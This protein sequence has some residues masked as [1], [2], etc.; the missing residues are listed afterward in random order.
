VQQFAERKPSATLYLRS[1]FDDQIQVLKDGLRYRVW[2]TDPLVSALRF[3][4]FEEIV[5]DAVWPFGPLTGLS[6]PGEK[7]PELGAVRV[8]AEGGDWQASIER[9]MNESEHIIIMVGLTTGLK[10]E[11]QQA[12]IRSQLPRVVLVVPPEN[13][14]AIIRTWRNF[15]SGSTALSSCPEDL[16]THA[17]AVRFGAGGAPVFFTADRRSAAAYRL[18]LYSCWLPM[19]VLAD[20]IRGFSTSPARPARRLS[21]ARAVAWLA[22]SVAGSGLVLARAPGLMDLLDPFR[23]LPAG[24]VSTST[25]RLRVGN[26]RFLDGRNGPARSSPVYKAGTP[27]VVTYQVDGAAKNGEGK[28]DLLAQVSVREPGGDEFQHYTWQFNE[29]MPY[30]QR[31][32]M[33]FEMPLPIFASAG[34]YS[35]EFAIHDSVNGADLAFRQ[36]FEVVA[37]P[38]DSI[39]K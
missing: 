22:V 30:S 34:E 2:L 12:E 20:A 7:L 18:A 6:R 3:V 33:W 28:A 10:W 13:R 21:W 32:P 24:V 4:R 8:V 14:E 17:L 39:F 37:A 25:G 1:F 31:M 9:L 19:D 11:F 5:A 35:I 36:R 29:A 15:V 27:V 16:P 23:P 26:F 38:F